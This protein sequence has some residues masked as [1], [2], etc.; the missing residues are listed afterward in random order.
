MPEIIWHDRKGIISMD[1]QLKQSIPIEAINYNKSLQELQWCGIQRIATASLDNEYK[2]VRIWNFFFEPGELC[3]KLSVNFLATLT[4]HK[5][6]P[7]VV[8][9]SPSG[10]FIYLF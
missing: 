8:R 9:F 7:S 5:A 6:L 10:L 4:D 2:E 1:I 3:P